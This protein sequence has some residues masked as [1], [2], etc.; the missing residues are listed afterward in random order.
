MIFFGLSDSRF[1]YLVF[2]F[3]GC[4]RLQNLGFCTSEFGISGLL[5][6]RQF[7]GWPTW[8][9]LLPLAIL[10]YL[11]CRTYCGIPGCT[12]LAVPNLIASSDVSKGRI[13]GFIISG[14]T[15]DPGETGGNSKGILA[16]GFRAARFPEAL[17]LTTAAA[18]AAALICCRADRWGS[19]SAA[20]D[21]NC[22]S[23]SDSGFCEAA[24]RIISVRL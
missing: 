9:E 5:D 3:F 19:I 17:E 13:D 1:L 6:I 23:F 22:S 24:A 8:R 14:S 15:L 12:V 21:D 16:I 2:M 10:S 4:S 11:P 7:S 18:A 20:A